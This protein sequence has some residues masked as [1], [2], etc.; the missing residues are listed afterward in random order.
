MNELDRQRQFYKQAAKDYD[1]TWAGHDQDEHYVALA[2][3]CGFL[4]HFHIRTMLDVGSGTGRALLYVRE[5]HPDVA[6]TGLEPVPELREM[7]V[8]KGLEADQLL[9]GDACALPFADGQFECVSLFAVLHHISRPELAIR[10]ALRVSSR[11]VFISDHNLYGMKPAWRRFL[12]QCARDMGL[13]RLLPFL[14]TRGKGYRDTTFDGIF[15]PF[16]LIDHVPLIEANVARA[17]TFS[18]KGASLNLYRTASHFAVLGVK[19]PQ[20]PSQP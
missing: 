3:L 7:A 16:S 20:P 18:T 15:F 5:R 2:I 1:K 9:D 17:Y 19:E 13:R 8:Q 6:L 4:D 10:E 12:K 14:L 11:L